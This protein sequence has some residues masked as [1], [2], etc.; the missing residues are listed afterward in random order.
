MGPS[1]TI[2]TSQERET[3]RLGV[4]RAAVRADRGLWVA[5]LAGAV[6][7]VLY[8]VATKVVAPYPSAQH[9]LGDGLYE[10]PV[11]LAVVLSLLVALRATGRRR[12]FWW[13]LVVSTALWLAA[14]MVWSSYYYVWGV[15]TPFPS[16][17]DG[18]YL[19]SYALVP[20][21][22]LVGFGG[23]SGRRRARAVLDAAVVGLGLA[24]VSWELL[25]A[26]QVSDGYALASVVG[27]AYPLLG[28]IILITLV[29]AALAGHRQCHR[30][31]G[32]SGW[33]SSCQ[34]SPTPAT[35]TSPR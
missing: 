12:R 27:I 26:P 2:Q 13:L 20:V 5:G 19:A 22:V 14:D 4:T 3:S 30:R 17:A 33:R 8:A 1:A 9:L 31:C 21:A 11:A 23:I 25:I 6:W 35:P 15:E 18:L 24:A 7:L 16:V 29:S 34:R 32:W 10:L 28:V